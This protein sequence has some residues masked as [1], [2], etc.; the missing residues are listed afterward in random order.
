MQTLTSTP[1]S[2]V[3]PVPQIHRRAWPVI[4]L[5]AAGIA[6]LIAVATI[7]MLWASSDSATTPTRTVQSTTAVEQ[8]APFVA[9]GH[10]AHVAPT[11]PIANPPAAG[12]FQ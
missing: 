10:T 5:V 11:A 1:Q 2:L 3:Q 7:S 6:V 9:V 8:P 12:H 4:A